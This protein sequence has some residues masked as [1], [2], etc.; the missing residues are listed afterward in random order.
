LGEVLYTASVPRHREN[1]Y[2][3]YKIIYG[4]PNNFSSFISTA[5]PDLGRNKLA[6]ASSNFE[7]YRIK[8]EDTLHAIF[9]VAL[10]K[11]YDTIIIGAFGCGAFAP[12]HP[13]DKKIY[14]NKMAKTMR[15]ILNKYRYS[16]NSIIVAIPSKTSL[17]Y[18]T[19]EKYFS[20]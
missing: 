2:F 18:T 13:I 9:K 1:Q 16:F 10:Y 20:D 3:G 19:F 14:V 15:N 4:I 5:A 12:V 11:N 8:I 7:D 17:N 6:H